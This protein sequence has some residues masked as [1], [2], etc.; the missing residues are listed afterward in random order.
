MTTVHVG[1]LPLDGMLVHRR[2]TPPPHIHP[3]YMYMLQLPST[4]VY[5]TSTVNKNHCCLL[6]TRNKDRQVCSRL[7][8]AW[9]TSQT[10]LILFPYLECATEGGGA[11]GGAGGAGWEVI[12]TGPDFDTGARCA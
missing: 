6:A 2:L 11:G 4:S 5:M 8:K 7:K 10:K 3:M 9:L 12:P 1:V